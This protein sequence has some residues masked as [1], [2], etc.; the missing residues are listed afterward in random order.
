[1][2]LFAFDEY[3]AMARA[4]R[5]W[6]GH[7]HH[8]RF[9]TAR[10]ENG[11]LHVS[12]DTPVQDE[13]CVVL[14][15]IAPPDHQLLATSMLIHTLK[16]AGASKVTAFLPYLGYTRQDENKD[17]QSLGAAWAGSL[18]QAS[19]C[20]QVVTMDLHSEKAALQFPIPVASLSPAGIFAAAIGQYELARATIVAPDE[21]AIGRCEAVAA[22][23]GMPHQ[24]VPYFTKRRV[25]GG[26]LHAGP[27][28][29]V[30][31]QVLVVDDILDT[32]ATLVSACERLGR[33]NVEEINILVT[34]GL[35]TGTRWKELFQVGVKRIFCTDS[36]PRPLGVAGFPIVRL[37]VIPLLAREL[38]AIDN[39][40]LEQA[41]AP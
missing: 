38:F 6:E 1:M 39:P 17:G 26:I 32:G 31:S 23:A 35:F 3:T 21:G 29:A 41:V 34:H 9:T 37:S 22:A 18:L 12:L 4:L 28:G 7:A 33:A 5:F 36:I 11:E 10:F 15:S 27:I 14:G 30:G 8:P 40:V 16:C 24:K 2:V 13:H 19:G 20:D 25:N